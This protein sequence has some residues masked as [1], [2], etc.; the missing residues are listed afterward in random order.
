MTYRT[1]LKQS[2]DLYLVQFEMDNGL[3]I[4]DDGKFVEKNDL[5]L[6]EL[7]LVNYGSYLKAK[8]VGIGKYIYNIVYIHIIIVLLISWY[9]LIKVTRKH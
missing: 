5:K 6:N 3:C 4:I 7:K 2:K 9:V 1:A 8:I